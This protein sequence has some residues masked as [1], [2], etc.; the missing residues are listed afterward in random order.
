MDI[1]WGKNSGIRK[2]AN[3]GKLEVIAH[4]LATDKKPHMPAAGVRLK[5]WTWWK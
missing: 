4:I 2:E 3:E 5:E 1:F